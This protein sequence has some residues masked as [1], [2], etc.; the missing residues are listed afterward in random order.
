MI[1][2]RRSLV[3]TFFASSGATV[4]QFF[5]SLI[6][7]RILMPSEIGVFSMTLV[8]VNIAHVFRDFGV[9][10]YLMREPVLTTEKIRAAIGVLFT[11]SWFIGAL[12]FWASD[13]VALWF[14]EP[15]MVPVM[16]LLSIGFLFIPFGSVTHSLLNREFAAA[17]QARVTAI[18]TLCYAAT[19]VTLA[20]L[21]FGTMSLAWANLVNIL[22]G[23]LASAPYRPKGTPWLPSFRK[24]GQIVHFGLGSLISNC[25]DQ[26]NNSLPDILL[27][28]LNG[29]RS[30]GLLSRANSTVAIFSHIAGSTV[31]YG[32][33]TYVS[34]THDRGESLT[35]LLNRAIALLTGIGWPVL[36]VTAVLGHEIVMALYG[37]KWLESAVVVPVLALA[38]IIN[39][40]FNYTPTALTALG[41]PYLSAIPT[42]TVM[43]TRIA[44]GLLIFDGTLISF[45]W[46][47]FIASLTAVPVML[48]QQYRYLNYHPTSMLQAVYPSAIVTV[49]CTL[50]ALLLRMIMPSQLPALP[51]LM[52]AAIP[53]TAVWYSTLRLTK[54][55]LTEEIHHFT[56][57]FK[58]RFFST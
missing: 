3:I 16:H 1:N 53:L 42:A 43:I 27:G 13:W 8:F 33:L 36:G 57:G 31:N 41:R 54:H 22:V 21:G 5:V 40:A 56:N 14:K 29:A 2:L 44:A 6:L 7:A 11:T 34:Q 39:M 45:A 37:P 35:P 52:I 46:A 58:T 48:I 23:A 51:N 15:Q 26:I 50:A 38:G 55:P 25:A 19:A 24:W 49:A 28:K 30:V 12:L 32:A 20:L 17:K 18:T 47:L 9:G 10:T 4:I